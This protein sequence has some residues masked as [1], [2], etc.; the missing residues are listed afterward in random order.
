MVFCLNQWVS[1]NF[2]LYVLISLILRGESGAKNRSLDFQ[3]WSPK[4]FVDTYPPG[5]VSF[6]YSRETV[7][8]DDYLRRGNHTIQINNLLWGVCFRQRSNSFP[9]YSCFLVIACDA[10]PR[11][12]AHT[13]SED[14]LWHRLS[15]YIIIV[16]CVTLNFFLVENENETFNGH[17]EKITGFATIISL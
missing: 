15:H 3:S 1:T 5:L 14:Y 7:P 11:Y 8:F 12:K 17:Q 6:F 13:C 2:A 4:L 9:K 16:D 10:N